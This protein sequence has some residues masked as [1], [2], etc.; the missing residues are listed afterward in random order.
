MIDLHTH[1]LPG[2]DDGARDWDMAVA[3]CRLAKGDGIDGL[4]ATPHFYRGLFDTPEPCDVNEAVTE[5]RV[6]CEKA[7]VY[8]FQVYLGADCHLHAE[9]V[10][11]LKAGRI[12]TINRSRY[13]LLELPN[14]SLPPRLD[15][16]IFEICMAQ[17]TP[18]ITHP[19]RNNV[20]AK[21]PEIL[22]DL[23]EGGAYAQVTAASLTGLFGTTVAKSAQ[24][25]VANGLVQMIASDSHDPQHRPPLLSRGRE[26]AAAI[27]G[28]KLAQRM[29]SDVPLAVI[30]NR[31]IKFPEPAHPRPPK[32]SWIQKVLGR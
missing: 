21:S 19:E 17:A 16:V 13:L 26:V 2:F 8:D 31:P 28:E 24:E 23:L 29:V 4:V 5:L 32:K 3:M 12:P 18:I 20:L 22:F 14:D 27:I 7:L 6:L 15:E 1:V 11:N 30:E 25:M 9:I 10:E